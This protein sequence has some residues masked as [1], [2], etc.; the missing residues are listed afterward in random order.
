MLRCIS[1]LVALFGLGAMSDLS[2]L[3]APK[4]TSAERADHLFTH[5]R[6]LKQPDF[7]DRIIGLLRELPILDR[8]V[9][10]I[11]RPIHAATLD[12]RLAF[13]PAASAA[14]IR[15]R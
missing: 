13:H 2:P 14:Q 5:R 15:R 8:L 11:V 7:N 12:P 4:R 1:L 9:P 10:Q 3:C 6:Q